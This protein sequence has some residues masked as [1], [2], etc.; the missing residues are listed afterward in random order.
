MTTIIDKTVVFHV[1]S[2]LYSRFLEIFWFFSDI[3]E[4]SAFGDLWGSNQTISK[5]WPNLMAF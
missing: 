4:T 2:S 3:N 5:W 1:A